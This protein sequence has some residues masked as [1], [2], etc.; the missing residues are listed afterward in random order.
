MAA[1]PPGATGKIT[2]KFAID[3]FGTVI[4]CE[5]VGTTIADPDLSRQIVSMVRT[6][7]FGKID[8]PGDI[9]EAVYPLAFSL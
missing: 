3:E 6:W 7:N 1:Q 2:V 4:F 8:K 5:E 9:T